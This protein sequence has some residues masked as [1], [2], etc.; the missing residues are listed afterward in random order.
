MIARVNYATDG[1][2]YINLAM[3]ILLMPNFWS[4]QTGHSL[5]IYF[6]MGSFS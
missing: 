1:I 3:L 4:E 6:L 5:E 2:F